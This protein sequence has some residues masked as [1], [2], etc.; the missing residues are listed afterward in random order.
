MF[1][2]FITL[3]FFF[4]VATIECHSRPSLPSTFHAKAIHSPE[5]ADISVRWGGARGNSAEE[6]EGMHRARCRSMELQL[7]LWRPDSRCGCSSTGGF[8]WE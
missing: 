5:G 6:V 8:L 2:G 1:R 3:V 4:L 7:A